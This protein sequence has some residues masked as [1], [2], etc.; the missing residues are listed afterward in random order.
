MPQ[1]NDLQSLTFSQRHGYEGIPQRLK[2]E[3]LNDNA[4]TQ[5]WN[6]FYLHIGYRR[7]SWLDDTEDFL[8]R[9]W[10]NIIRG[11]FMEKMNIP[12]SMPFLYNPEGVIIGECQKLLLSEKINKVF[13]FLEYIIQHPECPKKFVHD[14][15]KQFEKSRLAY[16]I[17]TENTPTIYPAVTKTEGETLL[18]A[19]KEIREAGLIGAE[20]HLRQA[21]GYIHQN[22]WK[23]AIRESIHAVESVARL[24]DSKGANTLKPALDSLE[25][26]IYLHPA[27]KEALIKLYGYTSDEQGIRHASLGR[28][29]TRVGSDEALYMLGACAS[30]ASYLWRKHKARKESQVPT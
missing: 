16:V 11:F 7:T 29:E 28:D 13:D 18:Q 12:A 24:I 21:S 6:V 19:S 30:F 14:I 15:K 23:G 26:Q 8:K 27:F 4:R 10:G 3:E 17:D 1:D 2:L 25:K 5:L 20:E 22:D 9:P